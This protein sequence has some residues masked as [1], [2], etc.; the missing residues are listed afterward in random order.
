MRHTISVLVENKPG[1]LARIS[2]MF[3]RRGFNIDSL[4]VGP[5]E[6]ESISR[7]SIVVD[8]AESPEQVVKQLNKLIN[9]LKVVEHEPDGAVERELLLVKVRAEPATRYQ[10]IELAE[11]FRAQIVD[12]APD[13]LTIEATGSPGKI[14]NL[15]ELLAPYGIRE[16]A[17]T[18]CIALARGS[19]SIADR[20][21]RAARSA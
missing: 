1:V 17:R 19:R 6:D 3:S 12:V 2:G 21:V 15:L 18:G 11:V 16:V 8:Q 10:V 14:A 13:A 7:M 20:P 5:T 9:V 4:A